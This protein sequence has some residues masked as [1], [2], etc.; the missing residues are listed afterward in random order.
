MSCE[1]SSRPLT[2][3]EAQSLRL[4]GRGAEGCIGGVLLPVMGATVFVF[5]GVL[6]MMGVATILE[7]IG[8]VRSDRWRERAFALVLMAGVAAAVA[9]LR[10][11]RRRSR[12]RHRELD[13]GRVEMLRVEAARLVEQE[14]DEGEGP[15]YFFGVGPDAILYLE[16]P[17]LYDH[18]TFPSSS[19]TLHRLPS[20]GEVLRLDVTGERLLPE[21]TLPPGRGRLPP[22]IAARLA[23][24]DFQDSLMIDGSF[25]ALTA[26]VTE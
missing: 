12:R 8:H 2:P 3:Q 18:V 10:K 17:W 25:D 26:R 4:A 21:A 1:I 24:A 15:I 13:A 23:R 6:S 9:F 14:G 11:Q 22:A 20:S 19:F 16:G 7:W 5:L